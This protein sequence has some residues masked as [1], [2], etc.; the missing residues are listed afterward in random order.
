MVSD[1][2]IRWEDHCCCQCR[3]D[4][5]QIVG[6]TM[7]LLL[8][9]LMKNRVYTALKGVFGVCVL[10][11]TNNAKCD[12]HWNHFLGQKNELSMIL[13]SVYF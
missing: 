2:L 3:I 8:L 12:M 13:K 6:E 7:H 4:F 9:L 10:L 5:D 11:T 1:G